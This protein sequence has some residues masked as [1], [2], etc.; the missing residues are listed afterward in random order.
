ME[1][2]DVALP[3]KRTKSKRTKK[4]QDD[5]KDDEDDEDGK[6]KCEVTLSGLLNAIDGIAGSE[7][8]IR[9]YHLRD[10]TDGRTH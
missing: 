5:A 3:S 9:Q 7:G 10:V 2:I 1:D 4:S 8:R 6:S